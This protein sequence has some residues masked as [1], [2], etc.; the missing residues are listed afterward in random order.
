MP[1]DQIQR[2]EK[3]GT[4]IIG[5]PDAGFYEFKKDR[6]PLSSV[7]DLKPVGSEDIVDKLGDV[8]TGGGILEFR[9]VKSVVIDCGRPWLYEHEVNF[10][11]PAICELEEGGLTCYVPNNRKRE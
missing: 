5:G 7:K 11:A 6:V 3:V 2:I 10:V 4:V 9:D 8:I 1:E